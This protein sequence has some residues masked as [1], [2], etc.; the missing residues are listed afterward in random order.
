MYLQDNQDDSGGFLAWGAANLASTVWAVDAIVA[1]GQDPTDAAWAP[2]GLDPVD[3]IMTFKQADG[4]FCDTSAYSPNP[5]KNSADSIVALLG[6]YYPVPTPELGYTFEDPRRGT[7]V[8]INLDNGTFR[9]TAPDG[10]DSGVIEADRM[11][12]RR[13]WITIAHRDSSITFAAL[14]NIRVDSCTGLLRD[15]AE[16]EIYLIRDPRG[17]E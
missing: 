13:G 5:V 8:T 2:D 12:E 9:F 16:H 10:Y 6:S 4:S 17:E 3:Y 15:R 11:N 7:T 1:A 14:A